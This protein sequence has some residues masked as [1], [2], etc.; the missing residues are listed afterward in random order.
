VVKGDFG[1][2]QTAKACSGHRVQSLS[3][4]DMTTNRATY[5]LPWV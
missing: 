5:S 4:G 3:L 2:S 1:V